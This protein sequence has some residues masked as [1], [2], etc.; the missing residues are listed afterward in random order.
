MKNV[1]CIDLEE[2]YQGHDLNI[3]TADWKK[4]P[5]RLSIGTE[6]ILKILEKHHVKATFFVVSSL[7]ENNKGLL[8]K[9][10]QEGHEIG[11]H[12]HWHQML[13]QMS[14]KTLKEDLHHSIT[15]LKEIS[16]HPILG[17]RAPSWS[18]NK[19]M[20]WAF[21]IIRDTGFLYDA[22]LL[23]WRGFLHLKGDPS[24]PPIPQR[25][26]N[27]LITFPTSV[28]KGLGVPFPFSLATIFRLFP[29]PFTLKSIRQFHHDWQ[30]PVTI[31]LHPYDFDSDQPRLLRIGLRSFLRHQNS[32]QMPAKLNRLLSDFPFAPM[33]TVLEEKGL[34]P[35]KESLTP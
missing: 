9:I 12:T 16:L 7:I 6:K 4:H 22:S 28:G 11:S 2:Y 21:D 15:R 13:T 20:Q 30:S 34:L 1:L 31:N 32:E 35:Q 14:P 18:L 33:Q 17:F 24:I 27:G 23:P 8:Q 26:P 29:L 19:N 5:H 25:L 3:P 10:T